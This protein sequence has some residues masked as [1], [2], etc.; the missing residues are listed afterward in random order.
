MPTGTTT[1]PDGLSLPALGQSTDLGDPEWATG[2]NSNMTKLQQHLV[3]GAYGHRSVPLRGVL[4]LDAGDGLYKGYDAVTRAAVGGTSTDAAVVARAMSVA[5]NSTGGGLIGLYQ[6]VTFFTNL[7]LKAG[8]GLV[9]NGPTQAAASTPTITTGT[10]FTSGAPVISQSAAEANVILAYIN[11]DATTGAARALSA[12]GDDV[13]VIG[14]S[15]KGG[16]TD[17]TSIT[18][19]RWTV[20]GMRSGNGSGSN[21]AVFGGADGIASHLKI[22]GNTG[23]GPC[24]KINASGN[25][26]LQFS[27]LHLNASGAAPCA[28]LD[29]D[30]IIITNL[31]VDGTGGSSSVQIKATAGRISITGGFFRDG[32]SPGGIPIFD[33]LGGTLLVSNVTSETYAG[34]LDWSV[35]ANVASSAFFSCIGSAF[36]AITA[37]GLAAFTGAGTIQVRVCSVNSASVDNGP[38]TV[39]ILSAVVTVGPSSTTETDLISFTLPANRVKAGATYLIKLYGTHINNSGSSCD[40]TFRCKVGSTTVSGFAITK[41]SLVATLS[42]YVEFSLVFATVGASGNAMANGCGIMGAVVG[43]STTSAGSTVDTTAAMVLKVT[44]QMSLSNANTQFGTFP[45]Q[46]QKIGMANGE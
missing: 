35:V 21:T 9:G 26:G 20:I 17:T 29:G 16:T 2:L 42:L 38:G 22:G 23:N 8:T 39:A 15:F 14:C 1:S 40:Y 36:T 44:G 41:T 28:Q 13:W 6:P 32:Q 18:G 37:A 30:G 4:W 45:A 3:S 19:V 11:V 27:A 31:Y 25:N 5:F 10:G 24:F 12:Q 33:V 34:G 46:I 7:S 43:G